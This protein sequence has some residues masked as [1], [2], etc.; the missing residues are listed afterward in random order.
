MPSADPPTLEA[1]AGVPELAEAEPVS[2]RVATAPASGALLMLGAVLC[3]SAM[4]VCVKLVGQGVPEVQ[5]ILIRSAVVIPLLWWMIRRRGLSPWG[6][7]PGLLLARGSLGFLGM[8]AYFASATH[9]PLG[10]ALLLTHISPIP[11]A[12]FAWWF[13]GERPGRGL[14]LASTACLLGVALIARPTPHAPLL[15][16]GIALLSAVGNGATYT[17][18]RAATRL[19]HPLVVVF[20][21][22]AVCAPV[23]AVLVALGGWVEPTPAQ[24]WLLA[25]MTAA[26]IVAQ[27][28]MTMG[29][30]RLPASRATNFFFLGPVLAL[31]WGPL[32]GDPALHALDWLGALLVV[33]S[34]L[35]LAIAR[36]RE[37]RAAR[38][39]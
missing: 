3:F 6:K 29:M 4:I 9:L 19:D 30:A 14:W 39:L 12:L 8:W 23:T 34:V 35:G 37:A 36:G 31:V 16:S 10:N 25:G 5:K 33:S 27:I 26:S 28:L 21:L 32:L 38:A 20:A 18:V 2:P 11:A 22:T 17:V 24:W 15:A 1:A 7:R 13:L